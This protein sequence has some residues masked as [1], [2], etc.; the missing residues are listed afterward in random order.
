M[1]THRLFH[2]ESAQALADRLRT[3]RHHG[4]GW[5][6]VQDRDFQRETN[7]LQLMAQSGPYRLF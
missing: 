4:R 7:E 1:T 6:R 5:T 3:A 2:I